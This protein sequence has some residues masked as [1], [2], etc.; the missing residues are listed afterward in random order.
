MKNVDTR[1]T[2]K[3]KIKHQKAKYKENAEQQIE[4]QKRRYQ[5]NAAVQLE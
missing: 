2:E 4:Y 5:E 3:V 1:K